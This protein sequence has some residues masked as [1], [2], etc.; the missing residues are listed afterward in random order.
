MLIRKM[1]KND[2]LFTTE[3]NLISMNNEQMYKSATPMKMMKDFLLGK[4]IF[5]PDKIWNFY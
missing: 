4:K 2:P 5:R 1:K 3:L